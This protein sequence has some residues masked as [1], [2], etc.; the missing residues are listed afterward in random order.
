MTPEESYQAALA[1][2]VDPGSAAAAG[3]TPPEGQQP[4][5]EQP[6]GYNPVWDEAWGEDTPEPIRERQKAIFEKWDRNHRETEARY[7]PY[8]VFEQA[9]IAPDA[10]E[11]ALN[12]QQ[13][14]VNDPR[15]F[16]DS[17]GEMWG[18]SGEELQQAFEQ[19]SGAAVDPDDPM[20]Q[21]IAAMEARE[22]QREQQIF[23]Q[24]NAQQRANTV[25][26][27]EQK[28]A[29]DLASLVAMDP[30]V[31]QDAVVEWAL[32]NATLG[33]NPSVE[34]AY[35][36]LKKYEDNILAR[37][38]RTAPTVLGRGGASTFQQPTNT[39][40]NKIPTDDERLAMAMAMAK[41]LAEG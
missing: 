5:G 41:Q 20:A 29:Q 16:W 15:G 3:E 6:K 35:Y 33:K 4:E 14:I 39:D 2:G 25:A 40:P 1:A 31:D 24:Q 23:E 11:Q 13:Q 18:F 28:V 9:G 30:Q 34:V 32:K 19:Q 36:E 38:Q 8:A 17:M 10:L 37:S 7:K 27:E 12:I 26:Y 22:R 21:R